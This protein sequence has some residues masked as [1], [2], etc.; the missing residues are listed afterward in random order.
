M[1]RQTSSLLGSALATAAPA[2]GAQQV[3]TYSSKAFSATLFPGDGVGPEIAEAVKKMFQAAKVPVTWDEQHI[4]KTP[5]P[6]T[7]SMVTRENLESVLKHKV[8]LKGPMATPI[9][10]GFRSLNLTLRKELDLYANVRPCF[11]LPGFKTRY[12]GVNLVT[13]RE[14]TEGEYSGL[15]HEVVPGVVESLKIITRKASLRVAEFAFKYAKENNRQKVSAV[16]KANIMKKADG[17]FLECCREVREKYPEIKYDELIV[18]NACMQLVRDPTQFDVLVMPNLYGDII[19]DLC[20]GLIGGLGLTPSA[21]IGLNNMCLAEAVH[22][23]APDIAGKDLANPTALALS[24][25]MLLRHVGLTKEAE[26]LQKAILAVIAEGRYRTRDLGGS[27][28]T[29]DFTK[30]VCDKLD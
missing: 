17:L 24:G 18:D 27:S 29:S 11:S 16:H 2:F 28:T 22:G 12:D 13:V 14:N 23:T 10:K 1:L 25:V 8:G 20:A 5:D 6:R 30:A 9:G 4:G 19:S 7:N 3:A 21:N 26:N 15:E